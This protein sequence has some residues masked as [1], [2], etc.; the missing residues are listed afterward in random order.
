MG[1][2]AVKAGDQVQGVCAGHQIPSPVGAPMP[3]PPL[4]FA[5]PLTLNLATSV[6]IGGTPAAV[7]GT[8][9]YNMPPHVGL[10]PSDPKLVPLT[11][12]AAIA[13]GSASVLFESKGAAYTGC[14][15]TACLSPAPMVA[16]T[17]PSV[18]IGS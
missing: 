17:T 14:T 12:E 16:G 2:P 8:K 5:A 6:L 9:G 15:A 3:A 13:V 10:H 7:V 18:L 11:Q 1:Q 4:P